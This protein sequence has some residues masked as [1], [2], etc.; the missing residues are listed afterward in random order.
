VA[1]VQW[2]NHASYVLSTDRFSLIAD[3]WL[4]GSAFNNG[5]DLMSPT[6][7][8][9]EDFDGIDY[10]WI[11]HEH[12]DHFAPAVL[13]A[14]PAE[15]RAR[16]TVIFQDTRDKKVL[17][18]C[19][20]VGFRTMELSL[21]QPVSVDGRFTA[22]SGRTD[23]Y[24][25]WLLVEAEGCKVLNLNDCMV[26][27][28]AKAAAIRKRTGSVDLLLSQFG[29]AQWVG[30]PEDR[31][32]R[33]QAAAEKMERLRYQTLALQPRF[34]IPFASFVY[35]SH[36]EN[37]YLND[38]L[39]NVAQV[40]EFLQ[41]ETSAQPIVLYPGDRW[42]IGGPWSNTAALQ[43]YE[44]DYRREKSPLRT[45]PAVPEDELVKLGR[46]YVKRVCERNN[47]PL[48]ILL[49]RVMPNALARHVRIR[50]WD[51]D[52]TVLFGLA[53]GLRF[54]DGDDPADVEMGSDSL[55]YILRFD[56]GMGTLEVNGRFRASPLGKQKLLSTFRLAGLNNFSDRFDLRHVLGRAV[57]KSRRLLSRAG[58]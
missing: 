17:G 6:L 38:H 49:E 23:D 19:E 56:W 22:T 24:D 10:I 18:F 5:W 45:S 50:L 13:K 47:V 16:I 41:R 53:E 55:A 48:A 43:A 2:V 34:L 30:N 28:A 27:S 32:L 8:R 57:S 33:R 52:R 31:E 26:N 9:V 1:T 35:F 42:E 36:E 40:V 37:A 20:K 15:I 29:Y 14:I 44:R 21:T 58:A 46:N 39:G 11:S 12:P 54:V 51:L 7:F 25:S 4:F 3:P